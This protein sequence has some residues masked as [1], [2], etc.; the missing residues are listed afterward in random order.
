MAAVL[1]QPCQVSFLWTSSVCS[2]SLFG[3]LFG[4]HSAQTH[5][6]SHSL[7][8]SC[9][10]ALLTSFIYLIASLKTLSWN[11]ITLEVRGSTYKFRSDIAES[12]IDQMIIILGQKTSGSLSHVSTYLP[13]MLH[14]HKNVHVCVKKM[15]EWPIWHNVCV[16]LNTVFCFYDIKNCYSLLL[17]W[18]QQKKTLVIKFVCR[19]DPCAL[20]S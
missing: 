2:E 20:T 13:I 1:H 15:S 8:G 12:R 9:G 19:P 16:L 17:G 7:L 11:T 18:R 10:S 14:K 3:S 6:Q 4:V 5:L